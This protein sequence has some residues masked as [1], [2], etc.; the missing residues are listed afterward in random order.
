MVIPVLAIVLIVSDH[1][2]PPP[3]GPG[4]EAQTM[5]VGLGDST[6]SGEGA[7]DYDAGTN[8]ENNN[9]CHRSRNASIMKTNADT[10]RTVNLACSGANSDR[11]RN[12]QIPRLQELA[13]HNRVTTVVVAVGA[14]DDPHFA[15]V[16]NKC[17]EAWVRR[18]DCAPGWAREWQQRVQKMVP[19]V[20]NAL[21]TVKQAMRDAGYLDS[22]YTLVIQSYAAPVG[23]G[24]KTQLQNLSGCPIRTADARWVRENAVFDLSL[25]LRTA[26]ERTNARFLDLSRAGESHEACLGGSEWFNRLAVDWDGMHDKTRQSHVLQESFHPNAAGHAQIGRCLTEFLKTTKQTAACLPRQDGTL[27]LSTES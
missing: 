15:E 5:L 24:L 17:V 23:P 3:S 7:G 21:N 20:E 12:D 18:A 16:L 13:R 8:G 6:M 9:W 14:N 10:N 4:V 27:G 19:K 22:S 11:V 25:G 26:A 2:F 1:P